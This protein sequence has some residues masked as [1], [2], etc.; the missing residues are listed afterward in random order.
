M[1][2][3]S[4]FFDSVP[5]DERAYTAS[6]YAEFWSEF[7]TD[8]VNVKDGLMGLKP[9]ISGLRVT[10]SKGTAFIGAKQYIN[11]AN[12]SFTLDSSDNVLSRIDRIVLRLDIINRKINLQ[13]KKGTLGSRPNPPSLTYGASIK[14]IPIAQIRINPGATAGVVTD[15]R[16]PVSSIIEI[17]YEDMVEEFNTWFEERKSTIGIEVFTGTS[18]PAGIKTGD[19]WVKNSGNTIEILEKMQVGFRTYIP[20]TS[21]NEVT[22]GTFKEPVVANSN[23]A[24]SNAQIRNF[25]F[26]PNPADINQM[27]IGEVWIQYELE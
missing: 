19:L 5:G 18:T 7:I 24:Y 17:P 23:N 12:L 16:Q 10:I 21:A 14:E 4:R 6:E 13:V 25:I 3:R 26:S 1:A 27:K 22:G 11:D 20:K 2:E 8:G 9:T 15:E